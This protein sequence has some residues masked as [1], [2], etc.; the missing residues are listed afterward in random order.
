M[1]FLQIKLI[2][3]NLHIDNGIYHAHHSLHVNALL[4]SEENT[5]ALWS[6]SAES[7][8]YTMKIYVNVLKL[9]ISIQLEWNDHSLHYLINWSSSQ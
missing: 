1:Q 9:R 3:Q 2:V 4:I 6:Q 7:F 5:V 8:M